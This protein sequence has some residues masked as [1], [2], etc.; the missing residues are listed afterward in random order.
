MTELSP[1][2]SVSAEELFR[3]CVND[4]EKAQELET[5]Y[6]IQHKR[7]FQ[8]ARH[9]VC[10]ER[11]LPQELRKFSTIIEFDKMDPGDRL[12]A[13]ISMLFDSS[14]VEYAREVSSSMSRE[15]LKAALQLSDEYM[16]SR[17]SKYL[18][19]LI[20]SLTSESVTPAS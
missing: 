19:E 7:V 20:L 8:L 17:T 15:Q 2:L 9:Q 10:K 18:S 12:L 14:L 3:V 4:L 13:S 1:L 11:N 6:G 16:K 5:L